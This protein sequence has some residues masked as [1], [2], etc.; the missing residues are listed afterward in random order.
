MTVSVLLLSIYIGINVSS[1]IALLI[2]LTNEEDELD[3][4]TIFNPVVIYKK[5]RV[6]WFGAF[7]LGIIAFILATPIALVFYIYKLCTVGRR[8]D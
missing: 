2:I 8:R 7:F 3:W 6:N 1:S 5:T 4:E